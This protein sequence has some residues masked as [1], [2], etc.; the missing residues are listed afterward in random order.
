M[1]SKKIDTR[2]NQELIKIRNQRRVLN[3]ILTKGKITIKDLSDELELSVTT[4][5]TIIDNLIDYG[6]VG[7]CGF[8]PTQRGRRPT[9]YKINSNFKYIVA[10]DLGQTSMLVGISNLDG[11]FLEIKSK[12]IEL[13]ESEVSFSTYLAEVVENLLFNNNISLEEVAMIV[14][15]NVGVVDEKTGCISYAAGTAIWMSQPL[16]LILEEH[17]HCPVIV[18]NDIN[19][20]TIGEHKRG[21]A[22]DASSF[23]FFRFDVGAKAGIVL[24]NELYEG[25]D[26]AA[27]EI[28]FSVYSFENYDSSGNDRF[29]SKIKIEDKIALNNLVS[30]AWE[31][32][33]QNGEGP[34]FTY[35]VATD[36][37]LN[38]KILGDHFL[39]DNKANKILT[40]Y[41]ILIGNLIVNVIAVL[42]VPIVILGG[43]ISY[44]GEAFLS[45][46]QKY[47]ENNCFFAPEIKYSK[48]NQHGGLIG[49][50]TIGIEQFI[51]S[52]N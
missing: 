43:E 36:Q 1:K 8:M 44:L 6:I 15:G 22:Q 29:A 21:V 45:K 20:S 50:A 26:G 34:L 39:L 41:I 2:Q 30:Y 49:A 5:I 11:D 48:M 17:F 27:G 19:L 52:I 35:C 47:V 14:I 9:C 28:G 31:E 32:V 13:T 42:N 23:V 40:D 38:I 37:K 24:N 46:L 12:T 18:K 3:Y 33:A 7:E 16:K 25:V 4:I 10:I 51:N